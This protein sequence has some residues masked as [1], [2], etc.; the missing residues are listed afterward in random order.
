MFIIIFETIL[1]VRLK[2]LSFEMLRD[3]ASKMCFELNETFFCND[4]WEVY[5]LRT[6]GPIALLLC[7]L[8][9]CDMP[10]IGKYNL[11]S[12]RN[13][14]VSYSSYRLGLNGGQTR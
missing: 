10:N 8:S 1:L 6:T 12:N 13:T 4:I 9:S 11:V 2:T 14:S 7:S 5:A 3:S